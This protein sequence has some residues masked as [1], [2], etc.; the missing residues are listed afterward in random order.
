MVYKAKK[1]R[2]KE[3]TKKKKKRNQISRACP[4]RLIAS[5]YARIFNLFYTKIQYFGPRSD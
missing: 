5:L 4:K 1:D 3:K 2:R